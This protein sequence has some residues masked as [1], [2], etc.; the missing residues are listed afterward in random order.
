M[1]AD[2]E[3]ATRNTM[4]EVAR[5]RPFSA[6]SAPPRRQAGVLEATIE[7]FDWKAIHALS[8]EEVLVVRVKRFVSEELCEI[9]SR[10]AEEEIGYKSYLN[11]P[12]VRRIGMAFYETE[13]KADIIKVYFETARQNI[14]AFRS[15][16]APYCSPI[17]T[18]RCT[19][20]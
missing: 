5:S 9:L 2:I 20:D 4:D 17:D 16:C 7:N 3:L 1:T 15:A 14:L 10:K 8:K 6:T 19:L 11:V 12:S 18:L 13:G